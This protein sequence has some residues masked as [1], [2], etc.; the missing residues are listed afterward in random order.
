MRN[1]PLPGYGVYRGI[2]I[3]KASIKGGIDIAINDHIIVCQPYD[4]VL[5]NECN[6][7]V[8]NWEK[9][10]PSS[11]KRAVGLLVFSSC[12]HAL[13]KYKRGP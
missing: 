3:R 2:D 1:Y 12:S 8:G 5:T 13:Q 7:S 10:D 9:H 6:N 4:G 11:H